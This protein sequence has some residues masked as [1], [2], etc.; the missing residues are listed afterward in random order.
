MKY[1]ILCAF[2]VV[3][4]TASAFQPFASSDAAEIWNSQRKNSTSRTNSYY[5]PSGKASNRTPSATLY[6]SRNSRTPDKVKYGNRLD[7]VVQAYKDVKMSGQRESKQWKHLSSNAK[8]NR[9]SDIDRALQI[10]Y[11]TR[12]N[13]AKSMIQVFKEDEIARQ[14]NKKRHEAERAA[15]EAAKEEKALE[16]QHKK[17]IALGRAEKGSTRSSVKGSYTAS[18]SKRVRRVRKSSSSSTRLKKPK[19]LFNDPNE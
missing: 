13:T 16:R 15:R 3:V 19:R 5:N 7:S 8:K 4:F 14:K 11:K 1:P 12:K 18:G 17:D 2:L 6:N 10:E 9:Q